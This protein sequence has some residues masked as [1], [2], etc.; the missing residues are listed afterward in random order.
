MDIIDEAFA[1]FRVN[2]LFKNY[3]LKG[4]ADKVLVYLF[5]L[6]SHMFKSTEN[7]YLMLNF[8]KD[9]A[10]AKKRLG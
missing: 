7:M 5:V 3:E 9:E 6:L 4:P 10:Q 2:V 8:R 1:F